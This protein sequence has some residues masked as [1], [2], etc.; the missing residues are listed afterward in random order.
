MTALIREQYTWVPQDEW[1]RVMLLP[2]DRARRE[3]LTQLYWW[4][5]RHRIPMQ[6]QR[7]MFSDWSDRDPPPPRCVGRNPDERL[8]RLERESPDSPALL[9]ARIRSGLVPRGHA[10]V[11]AYLGNE[12]ALAVVE[13]WVPPEGLPELQEEGSASRLVLALQI[14]FSVLAIS[15]IYGREI[16]NPRVL[17]LFLF[18]F[19]TCWHRWW[20]EVCDREEGWVVEAGEIDDNGKLQVSCRI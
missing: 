4:A 16:A 12:T 13:P 17:N 1:N 2:S 14:A 8:R 18:V 9:A 20:G 15:A 11:A 7:V 5:I 3:C 19:A 6:G 10:E